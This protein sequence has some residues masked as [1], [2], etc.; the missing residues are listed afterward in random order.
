MPGLQA[1]AARDLG[2]A[3]LA[4]AER[5]ALGQQLRPRGAMDGPVDPA[6][7]E[8]RAVGRVD[9]GVDASVVMSASM[10]SMRWGMGGF[11]GRGQRQSPVGGSLCGFA[12]AGQCRG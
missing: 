7:P 5:A 6:A 1:I 9:D 2:L 10:I 3:R 4:A 12:D 8:Q 11:P